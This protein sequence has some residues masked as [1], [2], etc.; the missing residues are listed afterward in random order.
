MYHS[1]LRPILIG[2]FFF[3]LGS[4]V[5]A[6]KPITLEDI[7]QKGTFAAKGV[8]GFNFQKDGLHFTRLTG[9]LIEQYDL[10]D[11]NRSG[12]VF[13][14]TTVINADTAWKGRFDGY[15][16]SSDES[17]II[18]STN[19][20]QIY[21]WSTKSDFFVFDEKSKKITRLH[22]G[23]KQRYATFS[24][25]GTKV[26]YVVENDLYYRDLTSG[27]TV[28]VT[29]DGRLNAIINGASDWVY[30][31]EFELIRAFEWSPDGK[32]LAFLRFDES[33]V[34][35]F[36][37]ELYK[38]EAYPVLE[39]FKYP[40]VGEKNAVVTAWMY[41]L[42][43]SR[44]QR[45]DTQVANQEQAANDPA[46]YY[47][48]R[49]AWTPT[50]M[51]CLTA[52]N[53]HQ[54]IMHLMLADPATGKTSVLLEEKNKYYID[55]QN[56][57]FLRDGSGFIMGSGKDGFNHLYRYNIAGKQESELTP[58]DWDV[59]TLYGVDQKKGLVYFQAARTNPMQ[60]ELYS[61]RLNGKKRKQISSGAGYYS[62]QFSS[63][64]D[65]YVGTYSTQNTPPQYAVY[66]RSGKLTRSLEQNTAL[67]DRQK[68][69]GALPMEFF[70]F[71]TSEKVMLNGW[72]L[73]PTAPQFAGQ[74]LP[75]L[76]FV[77]GGPGSQQV[78]DQWKGANYWWFQMLAQQG[79]V[80]ACVD[81]RGTGARGEEFK[82]M[83]YKQ[84]GHYEVIDQIETAKYLGTQS[85]V[86]K[87]RIGIF[88]WSYGGYMS[89]NCILKGKDVFKSAIAVAPVTNWK[90]YDSVYTERYMQTH[91]ENPEGYEQNSPVNF[92]D[93]LNGNFL[94]V[95][96]LA[97]DN[98]HF[99]H[100]AELSNRLIA[101]NKQ[102][103]TMIYPNRSHSISG[104]NARLHL[105]TLMTNFLRDK[106]ATKDKP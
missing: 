48:P 15:S 39:T 60:R 29:T 88:G 10:R 9:N 11:G 1:L 6:Q 34:P 69:Y 59:T 14:A 96:G 44:T 22:E 72:M 45:V 49:L 47:L 95:H 93:M 83:T 24:P 51:L 71:T 89:T 43:T 50:G 57:T 86:D 12:V 42:A 2:C 58:G 101:E 46:D 41:E 28:R 32:R 25:D 85:F 36:T 30:E 63:T 77:Y 90:W 31:E 13:D 105:Y 23:P 82:K 16:F 27:K 67:Q 87:E 55:L 19:T 78:L 103:D 5:I 18:L 104:D 106:L 99:Q 74:Q 76:M 26:A 20:E 98:V 102:F 80:V 8:P 70:H 35:E 4:C 56:V 81:N 3:L 52:M 17:K 91:E 7:W 40:K 37:M 64:F 100:T 65:Y 38:G 62:A 54:N 53:R 92:A 94:L 61:V 84:L 73:K 33:E 66:D 97:D 75:V 68:E 21:R 79:Y